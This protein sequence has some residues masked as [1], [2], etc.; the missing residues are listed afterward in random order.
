MS[1]PSEAMAIAG[2]TNSRDPDAEVCIVCWE[3]DPVDGGLWDDGFVCHR[4]DL[5]AFVDL[6]ALLGA[7]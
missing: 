2:R 6:D 5:G 3:I 7:P 1:E 4:C